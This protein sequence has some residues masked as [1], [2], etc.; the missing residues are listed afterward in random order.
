MA[1][2]GQACFGVGVGCQRQSCIIRIRT[3]TAISVHASVRCREGMSSCGARV[4]DSSWRYPDFKVHN[5]KKA[6][7]RLHC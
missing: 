2:I 7:A 1:A 6:L 3:G 4:D 5:K